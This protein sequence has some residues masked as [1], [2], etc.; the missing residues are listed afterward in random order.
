MNHSNGDQLA[1]PADLAEALNANKE[2]TEEVK[3]VADHLAVVHAVLDQ[4]VPATAEDD[5]NLATEQAGQLQKQLDEAAAK[6]GKVNEQLTTEVN[7]HKES[8]GLG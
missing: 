3:Q 8:D 7:A 2:A 1:K 6:L 5:L 4:T